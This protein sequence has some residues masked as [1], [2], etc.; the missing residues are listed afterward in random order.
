LL[1]LS[2]RSRRQKLGILRLYDASLAGVPGWRAVSPPFRPV[3]YQERLA[4][5]R[6]PAR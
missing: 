5:Q 3:P 2:H 4:Q 1:D 6:R